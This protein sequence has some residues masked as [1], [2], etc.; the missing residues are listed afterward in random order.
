MAEALVEQRHGRMLHQRPMACPRCQCLLPARSAPPRT[1]H[2]MGGDVS[3]CRP[4]FY[5]PHGQPGFAPLDAAL[6]LSERRTPWDRQR[7]GARLAAEV[8]FATAQELVAELTG[9][10]LSDHPVPAV[11]G[12]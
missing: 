7:A 4:Y 11:A 8:P 10:S 5:C 12:A 3:R 6:Q 2:T 1:V 9:L